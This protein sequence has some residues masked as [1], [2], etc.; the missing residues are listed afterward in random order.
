MFTFHALICSVIDQI[1]LN[2]VFQNSNLLQQIFFNDFF[3]NTDLEF[4]QPDS[5]NLTFNAFESQN[6]L[7]PQKKKLTKNA[8]LK[9]QLDQKNEQVERLM[10]K[11]ERPKHNVNF[12]NDSKIV[13]MLR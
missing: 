2:Q 6:S 9:R 10:Q 12:E 5:Q 7:N 1:S 4:E 3:V 11:N 8:M 13:T